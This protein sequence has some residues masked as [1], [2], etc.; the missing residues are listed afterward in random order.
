MIVERITV[1]E[2]NPGLRGSQPLVF[3]ILCDVRETTSLLCALVSFSVTISS[4]RLCSDAF[5][6]PTSGLIET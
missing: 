2:E 1:W 4:F 5:Q 6:A 3:Y